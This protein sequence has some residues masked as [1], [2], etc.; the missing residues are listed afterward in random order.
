MIGLRIALL[1]ELAPKPCLQRSILLAAISLQLE[2]SAALKRLERLEPA[3]TAPYSLNG[4]SSI[5]VRLLMRDR[6]LRDK[7]HS[8]RAIKS[9]HEADKGYLIKFKF[10]DVR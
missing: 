8:S 7:Q 6:R 1:S 5:L 3:P 4:C 10:T 2:R 9:R